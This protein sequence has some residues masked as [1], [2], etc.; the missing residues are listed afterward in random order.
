VSAAIALLAESLDPAR[1]GAERAIRATARA[2]AALGVETALVAP[3][4]R[5]G[6]RLEGALNVPVALRERRRAARAS[7]IALRL[8]EEARARAPG[9]VRVACGKLE[10]AEV[11]WS[12]GGVHAA[13]LEAAARAGRGWLGAAIARAGRRLRP[14]ERVFARVEAANAARAREGTLRVVALSERVGRDLASH[15]ALTGAS[16]VRN[17]VAVPAFRMTGEERARARAELV[18]FAGGDGAPLALFV[19]HAFALKGLDR[20]IA[21]LAGAPGARLLVIGRGEPARFLALARRLGVASRVAFAGE[22]PGLE[23]LL[24][25]ADALVHPSRYDPCSLVVLEALAA[26]VPVIGSR[27]DG[28]CELLGGGGFVLADEDDPV[29]L[30]R[31]LLELADRTTREKMGAEAE[32]AARPI[33]ACARELAGVVL[34]RGT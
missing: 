26:G 9:A 21:G 27:Q 2:L 10:G 30:S 23:R 24:G 8:A 31:R 16:V 20:A 22:V 11:L 7:E 18:R 33:E 19:A 29:E 14:V 17:G 34:G 3:A 12:H 6:E 4:D 15:H 25:A 1:G 5:F 28:A 32:K 13:A